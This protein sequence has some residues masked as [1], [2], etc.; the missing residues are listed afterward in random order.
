MI[1]KVFKG[2]PLKLDPTHFISLYF[3]GRCIQWLRLWKCA[4]CIFR[5]CVAS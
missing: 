4:V 5:G 1:H 3:W 2:L